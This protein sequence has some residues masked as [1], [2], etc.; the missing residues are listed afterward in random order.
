MRVLWVKSDFLLPPDTGGKIRTLNLLKALA[1]Q[2]EITLLCYAPHN[3]RASLIEELCSFGIVPKV[4][5]RN[6]ETKS[7]FGFY[8]RVL[9]NVASVRPYIVNKYITTEM[10]E[11]IQRLAQPEQFDVVVCDFLEMAWCLDQIT[12]LPRV[13]FEHN[14]ETMI[15]RRYSQ[16]ETRPLR[17]LYF[18]Y[19][20]KR[21]E[22]F[23]RHACQSSES[24]LS[25]SAEDR[26]T[27]RR[28]FGANGCTAVPTGVDTAFFQPQAGEVPNR[29]VFCGSMDWMPNIDAFWWFYRE[30][31][32]RIRRD[33][34]D[35]S[36]Y[37]VGRRPSQDIIALTAT[38]SSLSVTG[39]VDDVRPFVAS[40]A[41]YIVPLRVGG[42][43]RLKIFEA[44]AMRR[45][46]L[47][48]T[49]GAEG[50][51]V[52][53]GQHLVLADSPE[54]FARCVTEL[55]QDDN[56][57][58][59]IARAGYELVTTQY[60]WDRAAGILYRALRRAVDQFQERN[61]MQQRRE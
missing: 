45:C 21:L 47:S 4:V 40:G 14:V 5:F 12:S 26:E 13:L 30:V 20:R 18:A 41:L 15:W 33:I 57:R 23:E 25:V 35:I 10:R 61:S 46:V 7:G 8:R 48:T 31:Y 24:V 27:L 2:A 52:V 3:L 49:I 29:L 38:D 44:M 58:D 32:P 43:T 11:Q 53:D 59:T 9:A 17:K 22:R 50:L 1:R 16:V 39:T 19:E 34:P 56:K 51:P 6:E 28:E 60:S 37:L 42:G 36:F 54:H 55:L